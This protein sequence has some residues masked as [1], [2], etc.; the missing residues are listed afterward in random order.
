MMADQITLQ[1]THFTFY[2]R[3]GEEE[4]LTR[5]DYNH[6]GLV[7]ELNKYKMLNISSIDCLVKYLRSQTK[8]PFL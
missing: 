5:L 6:S 4:N 1:L 3:P 2:S 8:K 7:P